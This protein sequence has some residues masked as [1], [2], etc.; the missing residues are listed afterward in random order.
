MGQ[1]ANLGRR[2]GSTRRAWWYTLLLIAAAGVVGA[3]A[4]IAAAYHFDQYTEGREF[5]GLLC[6]ANRPEYFAQ[7]T[8]P[9][10]NVECGECHIGPGLTPKVTAKMYGAAELVMYLANTYE[11]PIE[12][13]VERL[14]PAREICEQCHWRGKPSP[15]R[16]LAVSSF[17]S[18]ET[19]SETRT[20]LALRITELD[21]DGQAASSPA[22]HWHVDHPV[23]FVTLDAERQVI[24]WAAVQEGDRLV[25]FQA[26]NIRISADELAQ[27]PRHEMDCLDC[28]NRIGHSFGKPE[29]ELDKAMALGLVDR[30]LP[31]VKREGLRLLSGEYASQEAGVLAMEA[32]KDFYRTQYPSVYASGQVAVEQ[33]AAELQEIF[34]RTVFPEMNVTWQAYADNSGHVDSPGCFR[35]HD[36]KHV[37]DQGQTIPLNCTLCHS[38]PVVTQGGDAEGWD[39]GITF[40]TRADEKPEAH[41]ES[42][43]VWGHRVAAD[44]SCV[45]C[46]GPI[47]YGTDSS[48][49]CANGACHGQ[50]WPETA[51]AASFVHRFQTVGQHSE[52][53]CDE[54]H[55][56]AGKPADEDC[57]GCHEPAALPHFGADCSTCHTPFG[58]SESASAWLAV[59]STTP[60]RIEPNLDCL[61]CHTDG[62]ATSAPA[63]HRPFA[64]ELCVDC[65]AST[66]SAGKL[67]VPHAV[68]QSAECLT[69]HGERQIDPVPREHAGWDGDSC[70]LCHEKT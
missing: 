23:Q 28:H 7:E 39:R 47:K 54:C 49:F 1:L 64:A 33:A 32:L 37:S 46:H 48:S 51:K 13:P 55:K 59:L 67:L 22:I 34:S 70:M 52:A 29:R 57:A 35:C 36:D 2:F 68:A 18:D 12:A 3:V 19:N 42:S 6:H 38:A 9:H 62:S 24:P 45:E 66:Y 27:L 44:D 17:A 31:Y 11:R 53:T 10:A 43:F 56:G 5:C 60:H 63:S 15:A 50:T 58:W 14:R 16:E 40:R 8:S 41:S 26:V 61:S 4:V 21:S 25:E 69:C 65:H 30:S 20:Q